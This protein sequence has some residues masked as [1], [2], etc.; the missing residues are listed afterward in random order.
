MP[1]ISFDRAAAYYDATRGY[2]EGSAE[3]IRDAIVAYT[4]IGQGARVLELGVGTGRIM[5]PFIRAGY[6]VT[7]VD[8]SQAMM[9]RLLAQIAGDPGRAGYRVELHQADITALPFGDAAFDLVVAVHVLHLVDDWRA[10]LREAR[11][12]LRPGGWLLIGHDSAPGDGRPIGGAAVPEPTL[13]RSQWLRLREELGVAQPAG[14]SNMWGSDRRL[15]DELASLGARVEE[16]T[17]AAFQRPP[18]TP[19]EM[20]EH[21]RERMYSSDWQ[22][23]DDVHGELIRRM[24]AW[25][26][27]HIAAPDTPSATAGEFQ[28]LSARWGD[29][30]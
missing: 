5:L 16:R 29:P 30:G 20:F 23:S 10:A 18:I 11:R 9:D 25:F 14:R 24:G 17:L 15:S 3:R 4:G 13:V 26:D 1:G 7:G 19:R 8:L 27:Q 28:V 21:L 2:G 12:V 6:D 22:T